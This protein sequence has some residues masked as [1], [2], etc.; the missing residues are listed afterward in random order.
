M[1]TEY[2]KA[3][4]DMFESKFEKFILKLLTMRA[5]HYGYGHIRPSA[6]EPLI[7]ICPHS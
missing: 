7:R 4:I 1:S 5:R 6:L 2:Y 3:I